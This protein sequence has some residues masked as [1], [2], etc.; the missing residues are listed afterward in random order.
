[1]LFLVEHYV[2]RGRA[3]AGKL[4][5]TDVAHDREQPGPA[6]AAAKAARIARRPYERVLD[7]VLRV[8]V[9]AQE[10]ARQVVGVV[11]PAEQALLELLCFFPIHQPLFSLPGQRSSP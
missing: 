3:G 7:R 9:V 11:Q 10:P 4:R 1:M 5:V 2:A 6:V 8:L